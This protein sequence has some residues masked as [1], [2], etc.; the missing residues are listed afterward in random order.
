MS[1]GKIT[2]NIVH[3]CLDK[4]KSGIKDR[5]Y[6]FNYD[7]VDKVASTFDPT[8]KFIITAL[9]LKTVSPA[10][11]GYTVDGFNFSNEHDTALAKGKYIDNWDHNTLFRIFD[12]TPDIKKWINDLA[13]SRVIAVIENCYS[14][15]NASPAGTSVFEVLFWENGGEIAEATRNANDADMKGG[16]TIKLTCDETNKEPYPPYT[17]YYT[18]GEAATKS[19]LEALV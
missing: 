10:L 8:N 15:K 17:L 6:L 12:N 18:G 19:A 3:N 16:W 11:S 2:S 9:V 13:D 4:L 14:N 1:C 5:L 7:D